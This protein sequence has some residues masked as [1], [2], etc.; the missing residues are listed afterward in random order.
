MGWNKE[1]C[2]KRGTH[3]LL[4]V[5]ACLILMTNPPTPLRYCVDCG[6]KIKLPIDAVHKT[7][8]EVPYVGDK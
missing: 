8:A 5:D 3:R 4:M 1:I 6:A 2:E 7:Y